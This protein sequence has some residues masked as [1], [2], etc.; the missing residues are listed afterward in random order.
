MNWQFQS[1][2]RAVTA[3]FFVI[4]SSN[5]DQ[6]GLDDDRKNNY[7]NNSDEMDDFQRLVL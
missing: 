1:S 7:R 4:I 6:N 2:F 3:V 5:L